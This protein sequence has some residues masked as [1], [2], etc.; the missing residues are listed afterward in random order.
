MNGHPATNRT[1]S[2]KKVILLGSTTADSSNPEQTT[3]LMPFVGSQR[4]KV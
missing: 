4:S 3:P 2:E 1:K